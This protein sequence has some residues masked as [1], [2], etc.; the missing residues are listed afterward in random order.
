[1]PDEPEASEPLFN[2]AVLAEL[3]QIKKEMVKTNEFLLCLVIQEIELNKLTTKTLDVQFNVK[4]VTLKEIEDE[5]I[6]LKK[7]VEKYSDKAVDLT[8]FKALPEK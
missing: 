1:M 5:Y 8:K 3:I 7:L 6:Y 2:K 4:G